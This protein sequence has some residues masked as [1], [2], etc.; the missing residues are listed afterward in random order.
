MPYSVKKDLN[1]QL[2][3]IIL[4]KNKECSFDFDADGLDKSAHHRL[5]LTVE[6]R[7]SSIFKDE[8]FGD[9]LYQLIED[10]LNPDEAELDRYCLDMSEKKPRPF[11]KC[12]VVKRHWNGSPTDGL[13]GFKKAINN[14]WDFSVFAKAENL[15]I[16]DGGYLRIRFESWDIKAGVDTHITAQAPDHTVLVD[17]AEGSYPYTKFGKD[18]EIDC[19][20]TACV[21]MYVEGENYSGNVYFERPS[22]TASNGVNVIP[23]FDVA[24]PCKQDRYR[25]HNW[26]G[27]NLTKK[28]WPVFRM[29]INGKVFFEDETFLR[30][31]RYSPVE[32]QIPDG[33][34]Q[35]NNVI[36]IK[37]LSD[38]HDTVPVAIKEVKIL[39]KP[40]APFHIHYT[41][42]NAVKGRDIPLLIET[43]NDNMAFD[44]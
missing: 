43:E 8:P 29:E 10:S 33:Y 27:M 4:R 14:V 15:K 39:Q 37:Y 35:D 28:E 7:M 5:Y 13:Y 22:L 38:Y 32:I 17:I 1:R 23:R 18:I 31:H 24:V 3:D 16:E 41:P 20:T 2:N 21:I 12:A 9:K 36:K 6:D 44:G 25:E 40:K 26:L 30:I 34:I 11:M 42:D 19:N